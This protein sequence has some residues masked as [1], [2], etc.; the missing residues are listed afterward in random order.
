[1]GLTLESETEDGWAM[2]TNV[3]GKFN[4]DRLRIDK[5]LGNFR[6]SDNNKKNSNVRNRS[7]WG[8]KSRKNV[9]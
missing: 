8:P 7:A 9:N 5:A 2:V 1:L 4:Y 6:K 3:G